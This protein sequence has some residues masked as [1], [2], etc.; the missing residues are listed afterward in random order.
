MNQRYCYRSVLWQR[1]KSRAFQKIRTSHAYTRYCE[2]LR[3][4]QPWFLVNGVKI[5]RPFLTL[6]IRESGA[7]RLKSE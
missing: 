7:K 5:V 6:D 2:Y 1:F 4:F 3:R